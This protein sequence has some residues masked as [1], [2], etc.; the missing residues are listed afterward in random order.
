MPRW[1]IGLIALFVLPITLSAAELK[2]G[3]FAMD[4]TPQK[5][6][7]S[8]NGGMSDRLATAAN[9]PIHA[10][11]IVLDDG[12][13]KVALVTVD[14]CMVPRE[15]M[16]AAKAKAEKAT[17]IPVS[18]ILISVTHTHS[19]PTVTGVFQSEPNPDYIPFLTDRIAEGIEKAHAAR[20]PAKAGWS[21]V[22]EPAHLNNRRWKMKAGFDLA[23]PF[24]GTDRVKMNPPRNSPALIEPA[25]PIDPDVSVLSIQT[26]D[27]K[28]L[29][30]HANY[31]LHYV[32]GNP[33]LSA[34]Y[35]GAFC[36]RIGSV[37][38]A[39]AKFM[40]AL[41]NGTSG[42]V[43]NVKFQGAT[44]MQ[45]SG[46]QLRLVAEAVAKVAGKAYADVK[47]S[48][49]VTLAAAEK[50]LEFKV[51]KPSPEELVRANKILADAP[52]GQPLKTRE[53]IYAR[54]SVLIAKYPDTVKLKVMA[55][56]IGDLA[57]TG[58]PCE[59]FTDIGL[60]IK[61]KTPLKGTFNISLANGY[62]GYL[63]T[64]AH[65]ALGGYETWRARSSYLETTASDT[66][67]AAVLE[68]L[69]EVAKK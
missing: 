13:T 42:D 4:V 66:I 36:D 67:T 18:N 65:H 56:R 48:S 15:I 38:G 41:S 52:K 62:N 53:Q 47:H 34:D 12:K 37:I 22:K 35:F 31:S 30:L 44:P 68:L 16:D 29:A 23:D 55:L 63:P 64:P 58:I 59:V 19:A 1:I 45:K 7:V 61:K 33:A 3:A 20:V 39:D 26:A 2:A 27:G 28:P 46:E 54:E 50:E 5:W 11:C 10:R 57:I 21:V 25:G 9:D 43:N 40:A 60:D 8:V 51:R 24:G 32:G 69:G 14:S 6:P 17:G 49:D